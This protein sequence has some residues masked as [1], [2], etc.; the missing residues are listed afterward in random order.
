MKVLQINYSDHY[1]GGG[2]TIAMYRLNQ[3]LNKMG[4]ESSVLSAFKTDEDFKSDQI[5]RYYRIESRLEKITNYLG[6]RNIHPF[7]STYN[8]KKHEYYQCADIIHLNILHNDYFS[9]PM[10]PFLTKNKP[11][12]YTLHDMWNFTGHC[13]YSYDCEKWKTGCGKCPYPETY[14]SIKRDIT[15]I[16]WKMKN[17]VYKNSNITFVADSRWLAEQARNSMLKKYEIHHIPYG[18]NTDIYKPM[19]KSDCRKYFDIPEEKE[20]LMI[21]AVDLNDYRKG[22]DLLIKIIDRLPYSKKQN[23]LLITMGSE[24]QDFD[25]I[26][27]INVKNLG[28]VTDDEIKAS[29]YSASDIFL[30]T[31]R[32]EAFG[33]VLLESVSC[34]TPVVAFNVGGVSDIARHGITGLLCNAEDTDGFA[35]SLIKILDDAQLRNVI[36][37]RCR[38]IAVKEYKSEYEARKYIE[39]FNCLIDNKKH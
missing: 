29:A 7:I 15:S 25:N 9:Y 24:S 26:Q 36:S 3:E 1:R 4:V 14:P 35:R 27:G 10:L 11:A 8:I 30:L 20:V 6:L 19:D 18:V 34:G 16:E 2:A 13:S 32:A 12:V 23:I 28:Y 5:D 39:L 22:G 17:W 31:S 33:L 37:K 21:S 38:E